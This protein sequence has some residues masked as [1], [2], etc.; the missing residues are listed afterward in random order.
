MGRISCEVMVRLQAYELCTAKTITCPTPEWLDESRE[1]FC[2]RRDAAPSRAFEK[3]FQHTEQAGLRYI[4]WAHAAM[5]DN[6]VNPLPIHD[7]LAYP[8]GRLTLSW[9]IAQTFSLGYL[10]KSRTE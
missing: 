10:R 9:G 3:G 4:A 8:R 6:S 7:C 5:A 2:S 1:P